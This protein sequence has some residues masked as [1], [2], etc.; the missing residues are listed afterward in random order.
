MNKTQR[1]PDYLLDPLPHSHSE[2][3]A[4]T[5]QTVMASFGYLVS[6]TTGELEAGK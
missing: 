5:L 1:L 3:L 6:E 2:T 4:L